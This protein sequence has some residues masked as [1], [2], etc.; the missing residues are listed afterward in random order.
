MLTML[1]VEAN[2]GPILSSTPSTKVGLS[3]DLLACLLAC[4]HAC[5][6]YVSLSAH[7]CPVTA[8]VLRVKQ[9]KPSSIPSS[10]SEPL[11]LFNESPGFEA[12]LELQEGK[13]VN[14]SIPGTYV[15][16]DLPQRSVGVWVGQ[17]REPWVPV[18]QAH[19]SC[20]IAYSCLCMQAPF[21]HAIRCRPAIEAGLWIHHQ[22]D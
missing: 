14:S 15:M 19:S 18:C 11:K 3:V 16:H 2:T 21:V 1:A 8:G 4:L 9:A 5:M 12:E 22:V 6:T 17:R 13:P 20:S 10:K 7:S